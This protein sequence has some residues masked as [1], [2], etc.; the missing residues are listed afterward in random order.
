M[1]WRRGGVVS[2]KQTPLASCTRVGRDVHKHKLNVPMSKL[3]EGKASVRRCLVS[4]CPRFLRGWTVPCAGGRARSAAD[5]VSMNGL[6]DTAEVD[7]AHRGREGEWALLIPGEDVEEVGAK[8][9]VASQA[10]HPRLLFAVGEGVWACLGR[11]CVVC[12]CVC[13]AGGFGDGLALPCRPFGAHEPWPVNRHW[14][15]ACPSRA[16]KMTHYL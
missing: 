11:V 12:V 4:R 2:W 13:R 7:E 10:S 14:S 5:P 1:G 3:M 8:A 15:S 16:A 9:V 6:V